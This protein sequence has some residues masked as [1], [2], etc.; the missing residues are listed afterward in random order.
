M[1]EDKI[2]V[3]I[4]LVLNLFVLTQI[5]CATE[6]YISPE[7]SDSNNGLTEVLAWAT[8]EHSYTAMNSGD[9][10]ILL[11]GTYA[12]EL[13]PPPALSGSANAY[14][15]YR[16]QNPGNVIL[17]PASIGNDEFEGVIYVYSNTSQGQTSYICFDGLFAEGVGEQPAISIA[18]M[19]YATEEQ[20]THHIRIVRCGAFGSAVDRNVVVFSAGGARD[21]LIEDC[22]AFGF[23][24]KAM[25]IYGCRR[26]NVRRV[27]VRYDWW[28][29][30]DYKPNDPRVNLSTYNTIDA[31]LEN[32][33]AL[34]AG[35]HPASTSPDRA[36]LVASGNQGGGTTIDG[37]E[38]V[39]YLGCLVFNNDDFTS[40][41]NGFE[42]NGGTG[43]PVKNLRFKDI[44]I[45][46]ADAGFNIHDNVDSTTVENITTTHNTHIGIRV[47]RY[48]AYSISNIIINKA[49]S[50]DNSHSG[51]YW[52]ENM[53]VVTNS[54]TVRNGSGTDLEPEYEPA[55]DYLPTNTPVA[56][57][58]R[59]GIAEYKYVDGQLTSE[60]L[61]PWP[62]ED[63]IKQ[64]MCYATYLQEI[65]DTINNYDGTSI[66]YVPG[67]C[68]TDKTL[69]EYVWSYLGNPTPP[70]IYNN[71]YYISTTGNDSNTGLSEAEAWRTIAY[72]ASTAS[73]VEP[74]D[75]IYIKAGDYGDEHVAFETDGAKGH[76][77]VF[78]GYQNVPGDNPNLNHCFGDALDASVM[79]LLDG[80]DRSNGGEAITLYSRQFIVLKNLQ[81]TNYETA[82]DGWDASHITLTNITAASFGNVSSSYSGTGISISQNGSGEGG[83]HN[84]LSDCFVEN[85]A[86]EGFS[87]DGDYNQLKN[88]SVYC[89]EDTDNAAMD[90]YI[91]FEGNN[92][93][94]D[95]CHAERVGLLDHDGHGIGFKGNCE[96]KIVSDCSAKNLGGG[97]YVRHRGCQ[98]NI[99]DHCISSELY[100]FAVRDGASN[101]TFRS[102]TS[103]NAESAVLFYDT[104][105]DG[106]AQY[107]GRNNIFENCIFRNTTE[108]VI[109]F[110]YYSL[111][112]V[113]DSNMIVNC[114]ID[115]GEYLFNCDRLNQDNKIVNCIIVRVQNYSRTQY[116]QDSIY[117]LN[118][119]VINSDFWNNGF[120]PPS[121]SNIL[122][123]NP[124][125]IDL[126]NHNYHLN[127]SSLCIDAGTSTDAPSTDFDGNLRPIG[128][129]FDLGAYEFGILLNLK[130]LLQGPCNGTNM[131]TR[132][133]P[134]KIPLSQPFNTSPWNYSGTET[135]GSIPE[136]AVD[137]VLIE[138]RDTTE[139]ALATAETTIG[140]QAAFLLN[141]GQVISVDDFRDARPCVFTTTINNNLFVIIR[142]RNH[143][144]I[145]SASP[146]TKSG[147]IY[148]YDFTTSAGQA[149]GNNQI[150]LD[151]GI[152]GMFAADLNADGEINDAD[153]ILWK[154][155]A[156]REGYPM[157]D[158]NLDAQVDNR[159]KNDFWLKNQGASEVLP[160]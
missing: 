155:F 64:Y 75:T 118:V 79:P 11:D 32:I 128:N 146:L 101:N 40:Q 50:T 119:D 27:V 123:S 3:R 29:G 2:F 44:I 130:V 108:N 72:A 100:G 138:L 59:G 65:E 96:Y 70:Y 30:D 60:P 106:G 66:D 102:C 126:A 13:H 62:Y 131:S 139:A 120:S 58:E 71:T 42:V 98:N 122:T 16:A 95:S 114:V 4:F 34:D 134:E 17:A 141:D 148:T 97:F 77:V 46:G 24:R 68:A 87:I 35:P 121:G 107:T 93:T 104:D 5:I 129:G 105:E 91:V 159:D 142:H 99:F 160:E 145:M 33:I 1:F 18:S 136:N 127:S 55:I 52:D 69:T 151:S 144:A 156:G 152:F 53:A 85:A 92:N 74:G 133:N 80:G 113:C 38:N 21:I 36:G 12:Q 132:L 63:V 15:T 83:D 125:F 90:Y 41:V 57:H 150:E 86:A 94:V 26:I 48:P 109:D 31:T 61:W 82:V 47:N 8:F 37:S 19:D 10:L 153:I 76:P 115:G 157:E 154:Q 88:C 143:L 25:Q 110:F 6:Y 54:T 49:V 39:N 45:H 67:L 89:D 14:T 7:G 28:E 124:G 140:R 112:S 158:A 20:M 137:W 103:I 147:G 84:I 135:V 56:G 81:I 73:P 22:F 23:G 78:E 43:S 149:Y 51:I 9:T 117:S 111:P 116:H